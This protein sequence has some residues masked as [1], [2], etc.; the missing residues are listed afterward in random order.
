MKGRVSVIIPTYK[1]PTNLE[2]A[3]KSVLD[4]SYP[5]FEILIINDN[6]EDSSFNRETDSVIERLRI[7]DPH[8]RIRYI[9]HSCNRNGA[10]AR[11]TGLMRATGEFV[12]FLER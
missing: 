6:G 12:S 2:A 8:G 7:R 1:R 4:Q 9:K 10:A 3:V 11:N 5:D